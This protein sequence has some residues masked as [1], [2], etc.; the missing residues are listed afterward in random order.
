MHTM[1]A[2][3]FRGRLQSPDMKGT[4]MQDSEKSLTEVRSFSINVAEVQYT[5]NETRKHNLLE[6]SLI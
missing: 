6:K 3:V 5:H 2:G 4:V 1:Y